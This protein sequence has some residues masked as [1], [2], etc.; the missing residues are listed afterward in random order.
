VG[1]LVAQGRKVSAV[2]LE[3]ATEMTGIN[4]RRALWQVEKV[5]QAR[6]NEDLMM[7]G[8]TLR[9]PGSTYIDNRSQIA[10]D[11]TIEGGCYITRSKIGSGAY[12]ESAV[13]LNESTVGERTKIKQG[14][15]LESSQIGA[16]CSVGPYAHLR[17]GSV[18]ERE[19]KIGNFVEL[20]KSHMGEG[21][22]AS[23]LSYIGDAEV[24]KNVNL[25][26]G[27]ITCNYDGGPNKH[28][29]IIEDDVFV[30][31]DSQVVAP[32]RIGKGSY[33]AS[34]STITQDVPPDS[35]SLSR[36]RQTTKVGYASKL[37]ARKSVPKASK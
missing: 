7:K 14:S 31:S 10:N 9:D 5:L 11:V 32:V 19:V 20:K 13:R 36:G 23:H 3:D 22:K 35:L 1:G 28:K 17:P 33:V 15:Y 8:V 6:V 34:G 21:S 24:G 12:L 37:K 4:D 26:C 27:F 16:E 29:T 2:V 30:G 25:G 18:L